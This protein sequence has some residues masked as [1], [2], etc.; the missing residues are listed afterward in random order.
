MSVDDDIVEFLEDDSYG[1]WE[2][3]ALMQDRHGVNIEDMKIIIRKLVQISRVSLFKSTTDR[4]QVYHHL[5]NDEAMAA[6][7]ESESWA[8]PTS[9]GDLGVFA[10]VSSMTP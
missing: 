8:V 6:I 7:M 9:D 4:T 2:I 10:T 1:L 3:F 5:S